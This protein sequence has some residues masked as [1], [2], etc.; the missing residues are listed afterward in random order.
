MR[1][2]AIPKLGKVLAARVDGRLSPHRTVDKGI[3][4]VGLVL[5]ERAVVE[6]EVEGIHR[7]ASQTASE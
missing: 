5:D 2:F 3:I 4:A 1:L 6:V 7:P